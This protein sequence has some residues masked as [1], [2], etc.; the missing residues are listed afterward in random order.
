MQRD[1]GLGRPD[2]VAL[3]DRTLLDR[4]ALHDRTLRLD[5]VAL[6]DRTPVL[7]RVP[8]HDPV[9]F[10]PLCLLLSPNCRGYRNQR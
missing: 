5:R 1:Q 8:P 3:H 6:R 9:T 7:D 10:L 4:V 2:R